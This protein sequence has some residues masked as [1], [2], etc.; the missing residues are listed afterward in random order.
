MEKDLKYLVNIN[1]VQMHIMQKSSQNYGVLFDPYMCDF[2]NDADMISYFI[3]GCSVE[4][5]DLNLDLMDNLSKKYN[6]NG[7][8]EIGVSRNGPRSFTNTILKNKPDDIIYLGIDIN[9]KSYLN[10]TSKNIYTIQASSFDQ[11]TIR[12]Y[13]D[14]V[15]LKSISLLFIDG[16]HSVN[17]VINDW[18]YADLLSD[19]G[20]VIF[21]D[22]NYHPGPSIFLYCIDPKLF[23]VEKY[24]NDIVDD[25]G[26]AV[27]YRIYNE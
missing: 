16:D 17:A 23:R 6:N 25:Y 14:K 7:I 11:S 3:R 1:G 26:M 15:N 9:D 20:I 21:H 4:V 2:N 19:N 18:K 8:V 12:E 22:S 5:S 10:N 27:A 13:M 24:F